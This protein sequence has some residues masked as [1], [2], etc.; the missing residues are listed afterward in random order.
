VIIERLVRA[1]VRGVKVH[2]LAKAPHTLKPDKL[3]E[4]GGGLRILADV[5]VDV[6]VLHPLKLY[7]KMLLADGERR[8]DEPFARWFRRS[9][10]IRHRDRESSH[11]RA[12]EAMRTRRSARVAPARPSDSG[13]LHDLAKR[14]GH[15]PEKL[16]VERD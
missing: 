7:G 8:I 12:T 3:I 11:R 4:R 5:G 9:P 1:A 10:R 13:L 16:A 2:I 14:A 15:D 6:R